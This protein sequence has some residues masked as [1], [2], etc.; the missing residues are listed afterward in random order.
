[1]QRK[2]T[3]TI[4][5]ELYRGLHEQIG[6]GRI[7]GFIEELVREHITTQSDLEEGYRAMAADEEYEREAWEWAEGLIGDSV[8]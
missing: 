6:R 3:I 2:L 4:D 8:A 5:E 7:S 1:M